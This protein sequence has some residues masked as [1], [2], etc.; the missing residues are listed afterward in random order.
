MRRRAAAGQPGP[1]DRL[2]VIALVGRPNVGKSTLLARASGRYVETANLPGTTV[3]AEAREIRGRSGRALLVDLPGTRSLVDRPAGDDPFWMT[4]LQARPDAI[5]VVA[6]AGD[7]ARHLP[8]ALACRDLG[9]PVVVAANLTDEASAHGIELDVGLL[10]QRLLM[11]VVP[12]VARDPDGASAE[13]G[14]VGRAIDHAI[15]RARRRRGVADRTQSPRSTV[16]A[17]LY[18]ARVEWS[19]EREAST[20][21]RIS[22]SLGAAAVG[23]S[24]IADAVAAGLI[25]PRG[26][27]SI[28][29]HDVL[30]PYRRAAARDWVGAATRHRDVRVPLADRLATA[31]V[32]PATGIPL[33]VAVLAAVFAVVAIGGGVAAALLGQGWATWVSPELQALVHGAL[34]NASLARAV[35]WAADDGVL[36]MLT[37][38]IPYV[39]AFTLI[40]AA[41]EDSGYLA[42]VTVLADRAL[43]AFGL[44]GRAAIPLLVANSCNVPAIYATRV[45]ATRRERVLAA[46]LA[47]LV[48]CSARSAIVLA[49]IVP[50]AGPG[51]AIAAFG[52]IAAV[53]VV[54]AVG[55]NAI[56]PGRQS[57]LVLDLA[58]LRLPVPRHVAA[59]AW[60]RFRGFVR[61]AAPV[62]LL[63]SLGLGLAFELGVVTSLAPAVDGVVGWTLGL[64]G[65]AGIALVFGVLRKELALQLL[66]VLAAAQAGGALVL[67]QILTPGQAF[68]FAIVTSV[69]F[70]CVA[71]FAALA[72][73]LGRRSAVAMTAASMGLALVGGAVLARLV[74]IA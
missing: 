55:A 4:L 15:A 74:G 69:S 12:T 3:A 22:P 2:P 41:L 5:L 58:P 63:G 30:A 71:T 10:A 38:G 26:A 65:I 21:Y 37:V 50:L 14:G 33:L 67:G 35:L 25:S 64:P 24:P 6:D 28:A 1:D 27:A 17:P 62:M 73:E 43:G 44:P 42:S 9:L 11:P 68:V 72:A 46:F 49:A 51:P 16:P 8:L 32:R 39:L 19:L 54:A 7:L 23:A 20:T 57:P 53:T 36:A 34:P 70:P 56:L 45:L 66:L 47:T 60:F 31:S 13:G 52:L 29:M 18:P 48:P 59:K 40:V 61:T